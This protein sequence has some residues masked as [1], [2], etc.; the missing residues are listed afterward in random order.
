MKR[1]YGTLNMNMRIRLDL[2]LVACDLFT[3]VEF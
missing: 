3:E 2:Q 1:V